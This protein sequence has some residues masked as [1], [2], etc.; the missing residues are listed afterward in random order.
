MQLLNE[1]FRA[2]QRNLGALL[3][4][5]FF[6]ALMSFAR[7]LSNKWFEALDKE[8]VSPFVENGFPIISN[9]LIAAG[10]AL[11]LSVVFARMGREID[12]PFWKVES[13]REA[14]RRFFQLWFILILISILF[15]DIVGQLIVHSP[16]DG[17][18]FSILWLCGNSFLILIGGA[19]MFQS[20]CR[21]DE[22]AQA[23]GTLLHQLPLTLLA[24]LVSFF[25][26]SLVI[27]IMRAGILPDLAT[28][29]L[30]IIDGYGTCLVFAFIWL[31][32]MRHRDEESEDEDFDF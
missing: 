6:S 11:L 12:R 23:M 20:H 15:G 30:D 29:I 22:I 25:F 27:E 14:I 31:I 16:D 18:I 17:Q 26:N 32:C 4:Y 2:V 13:D 1:A 24:A 19:I 10:Y 5:I 28:P 7:V 9:V 21:K 8:T 3:A